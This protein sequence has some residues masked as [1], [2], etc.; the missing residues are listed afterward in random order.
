MKKLSL[1]QLLFNLSSILQ[2]FL[3]NYQEFRKSEP[4]LSKSQNYLK[5]SPRPEKREEPPSPLQKEDSIAPHYTVLL[6][7]AEESGS[8]INPITRRFEPLRTKAK[9]CRKCKAPPEYLR[10][11]GFYRPKKSDKVYPRHTCKVCAAEYAPGARR[12]KPKHTCPYCAYALNPKTYRKNF[13]VYFCDRDDCQHRKLHPKGNRY[14]EKDWLFDYDT[15]SSK[16]PVGNKKL[17]RIKNKN[18]L[19]LEMTLYVECGLTTREVKKVLQ[20]LYGKLILKSHQTILNHADA[21]ANHLSEHEDLLP[22]PVSEKVCED[23]T[24]VRYSGKWGYLFRA[25]NPETKGIIDEYFSPHRDTKS[26]ITL[27]KGVTEKYLKNFKDPCYKL[28]SDRA[29]IYG[30]AQ[31]YFEKKKKAKIELFQ[32]KGIFDE[33]NEE[34]A[35]FRPEKQAIERS[36][37]SLKSEIKRRRNFSS[38]KGAQT[39]CFLHKIYYNHLRKHSELDDLPPAPLY[40]RCGRI[41][42]N[43]NDLL[44]FLSEKET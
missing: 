22:V 41:V 16:L 39:F 32:I 17:N 9:R 1:F 38:F 11:H 3:V 21:L 12:H 23:E 2:T 43:W 34:N 15:L 36:F 35:E 40:L 42:A 27:N 24:Y 18:L 29:P 10:N 31:K 4:R 19:D 33:P 37:E 14:S 7:L 28:I 26:C 30:A 44:Q 20:K 6:K 5:L 25:Y 8:P 13:V